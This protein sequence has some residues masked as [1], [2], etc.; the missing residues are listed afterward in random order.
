MHWRNRALFFNFNDQKVIV[1]F[2]CVSCAVGG[3]IFFFGSPQ[4]HAM[5][6][7][8]FV[9]P[10]PS[11]ANV[12]TM[13]GAK[14]DG[15]TDDTA[16]IQAALN[17]LGSATTTLYFPAGTYLITKTLN[18]SNKIY[19]NIIGEDPSDTKIIWGGPSSATSTMLYINGM[20]YSRIDRLTFNGQG[21]A[22][23]AVDQSWDDSTGYFD[24]QNQYAD[25][26]FENVGT[27]FRCGNLGYGCAETSMLRDQYLN[28][29]VAGVAMKNYN[30]LDMWVWDS[31]FRNDAS[32]VT[33]YPGA[34]NFH[35]F[36]SIF[37]NST[38]S[39]ITIGAT[40]VFN[41]YG[42]YSIDSHQFLYT[43]NSGNPA[44]ITI[45]DNTILDTTAT[46]S[47]SVG[48]F[49]PVVLLDN[50]IRSREGVTN[51]PVVMMT[52]NQFSDLFSMG[53][54]FTVSSSTYDANGHWHS[55]NDQVVAR[56]TINPIMPTLPGTPPNNNPQIFEILPGSTSAQIQQIINEA[57]SSTN[58]ESIVHI[59]AGTYDITGT[60]D[61][62][63]DSDL[64]II[65]DGYRSRLFWN[66]TTTGPVIRLEG[67]SKAIL[68]E[69]SVGGN[70]HSADGI[71]ID[72][73]DQPGS[74]IFMESPFLSHSYTN[75]F[76]D[77]L[78]YTNVQLHDFEHSDAQ[79]VNN[80]PSVEV[81][82]GPYAIHNFWKGGA[83]N[84]FAGS[85][86]GNNLSYEVS[87]GGHLGIRYTWND[88]GGGGNEQIADA[89]GTSTLSYIGSTLYQPN[90]SSGSSA[91]LNN[92]HG[93]AA[94]VNLSMT[95]NAYING[96]GSNGMALGLG[97]V[98][99]NNDSFVNNSTPA[100]ESELLNSLTAS[101]T[102]PIPSTN[103]AE[104]PEQGTANESFL[105]ATLDQLRN[106]VPSVLSPLPSNVTDVRFYRVFVDTALTGIHISAAP[107]ITPPLLSSISASTAASAATVS[108][109]TDE[110]ADTQVEY[111]TTPNAYA[112]STTYNGVY[113]TAHTAVLSPLSACTTYHYAAIS[114]DVYG[115]RSV[116]PDR[117]L[118]TTGC[119]SGSISPI[120]INSASPASGFS[121]VP[122]FSIATTSAVTRATSTI[123]A[124]T[125]SSTFPVTT[126]TSTLTIFQIQS[127]L[128]ILSSFGV[129][130][131]TLIKV[132]AAL[133]GTSIPSMTFTVNA[134]CSFTRN[135]TIGIRGSDV[136][137]LQK[138]LLSVGYMIQA[139]ATGYFGPETRAAVA[140]WQRATG[141]I[142][143][144]GY[145]GAIS[146]GKWKIWAETNL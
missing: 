125:A 128:S 115:N 84:I 99:I 110:V 102:T 117:T 95:C 98:T 146:R 143:A 52:G 63:A 67:P 66:G 126:Q 57:A 127:I 100:V 58:A 40:G 29:D 50:T 113:V 56:N 140:T 138:S 79:S 49:G 60:I 4:A 132:N 65:G 19:V 31:L 3:A 24:T 68:R 103:I 83:T 53:N 109:T 5:G 86:S 36:N 46:T 9:G 35:V 20:A 133:M 41:F 121:S 64:Q 136:A 114:I 101:S 18:L 129:G 45:N 134:S 33:N 122:S 10:F 1:T 89:A 47:I 73:A 14:G 90:C 87:N 77:A 74:S 30:A 25:D 131:A 105:T 119:P 106:E 44:N 61:V 80:A 43:V 6:N 21:V 17:D 13:Y 62:P 144:Y 135:L 26:T 97:L 124:A 123:V 88:A 38:S 48:N 139:G 55:V 96:N 12:Q 111:G 39:D 27:G 112:A 107:V 78:D 118:K 108:W 104:I 82:G 81:T 15:T 120:S 37:E 142:P 92:F 42:N 22:N 11:W 51:G 116:S 16:A 76:A 91:A 141:V 72:N 71:E 75:F 28:D 54:T 8:D 94:L 145:F 137:C 93:T 70:N 69:I 32:G 2:I 130:N 23:V 7:E 59:P 85:S 34:G